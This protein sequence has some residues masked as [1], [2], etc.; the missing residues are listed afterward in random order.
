MLERVGK[1]SI[2][3]AVFRGETPATDV[4]SLPINL[5]K[6]ERLVWIEH[7]VRYLED[8]VGRKFVG[9]SR[10]VSVRVMRGVYARVGAFEG[11]PVYNTERVEVATGTLYVTDRNLYFYSSSHSTR[12]P[13]RKI[14]SFEKFSDVLGI[15]R[16]AASAKPQFFVN[17][18]GWLLY[19]LVSSLAGREE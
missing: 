7:G 1:A 13:Y 10:G 15:M 16:D 3:K 4:D 11:M 14:V 6:S 8:R 18:D 2:L 9:K 12:I 17:G 19:N 5:Q